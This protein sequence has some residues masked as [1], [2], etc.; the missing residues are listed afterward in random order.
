MLDMMFDI[1]NAILTHFGVLAKC[2]RTLQ[3][4]KGGYV[5]V[6]GSLGLVEL[7]KVSR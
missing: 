7:N 3:F 6:K 4:G 5:I 2:D 1:E